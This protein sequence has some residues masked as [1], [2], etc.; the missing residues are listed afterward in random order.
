[1]HQ[2]LLQMGLNDRQAEAVAALFTERKALATGDY[3]IREGD[4]VKGIGFV[5]DGACRYFYNTRQGD[6]ITR[7][8]TLKA[9]F[10][11]SLS[12]FI[13]GGPASETIQA[14][15]PSQVLM[16]PKERWYQ[17][18]ADHAFMQ[19]LWTRSMEQMYLGMEN[20]V[21]QLIALNAAE[22]YQWMVHNQ[23]EFI[24]QV[25]DKYLASM[26]GITPR[27]LSR[28]SNRSR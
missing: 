11:T 7:W 26:L 17:L 27:H 16:A 13:T 21:F 8:V 5:V 22:R 20:R 25:P 6:E 15:V 14:I 2:L 12:G 10:V 3:L 23:P 9:N 28:L 24:E 4:I 18:L 1:M 19:Q